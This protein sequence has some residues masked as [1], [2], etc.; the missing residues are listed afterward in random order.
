MKCSTSLF[1]RNTPE[2]HTRDDRFH[3]ADI[4]NGIWIGIDDGKLRTKKS[5]GGAW[6]FE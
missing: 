6:K 1:Q 3:S 2:F 5:A 4:G